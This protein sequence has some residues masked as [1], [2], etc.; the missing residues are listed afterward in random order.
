[1]LNVGVFG[2]SVA[3][4][5][6]KALRS[7]LQAH[8]AARNENLSVV[9]ANYSIG[10]FK[11]PQQVLALTY[12]ISLGT[13]FDIVINIDGV[14]EVVLSVFENHQNGTFPFFPRQWARRVT[15]R[16]DATSMAQIGEIRYLRHRQQ[17]VLSSALTSPFR[18][19]GWY[20]LVNGL[21]LRRFDN[22]RLIIENEFQA[23]DMADTFEAHGP[24]MLNSNDDE[25]WQ[26]IAAVWSRSSISMH[27]LS[28]TNGADYLHF[29]QPNQYVPGSKPLSDEELANGV[30][31]DPRFKKGVKRG[32]PELSE[33]RLE[34]EKS[35]V[36]AIDAT[37]VF[38]DVVDSLYT[39]RCCHF[40][41]AARQLFADYIL[42]ELESRSPRFRNFGQ[43]RRAKKNDIHIVGT[44]KQLDHP[45]RPPKGS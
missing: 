15:G 38:A 39:D 12:F 29:L 24:R 17:D 9:V 1:M 44:P 22:Q 2:G 41:H 37:L 20:G 23:R 4:H 28:I 36:N 5:M 10:G 42:R 8:Y 25:L 43:P 11:Q 35:G 30:T 13:E 27:Q 3:F 33:R 40:N 31:S 45:P 19:S 14:N 7:A 21:R 16:L 32:Y 26:E 6:S 34:L 18:W